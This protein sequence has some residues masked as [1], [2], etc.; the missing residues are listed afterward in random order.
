[1]EKSVA[2]EVRVP[3]RRLMQKEEAGE[4]GDILRPGDIPGLQVGLRVSADLLSPKSA[5]PRLALGLVAVFPVLCLVLMAGTSIA[6]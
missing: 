2:D 4:L 5:R 1:M 3:L 6:I